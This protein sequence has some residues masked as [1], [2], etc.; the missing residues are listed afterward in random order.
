MDTT[1][2]HTWK[3]RITLLAPPPVPQGADKKKELMRKLLTATENG[4]LGTVPC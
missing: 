4:Q 3:E 2:G 1:C